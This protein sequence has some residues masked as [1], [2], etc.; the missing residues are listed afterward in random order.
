MNVC[1]LMS[2][3]L[4]AGAE[5]HLYNLVAY[6][7][8]DPVMRTS[9]VLL[10]RGKLYNRL[11]KLGIDVCLIDETR[12]S[13]LEIRRQLVSHLRKANPAI[14][15]SHRYKEN[16]L[17]AQV[18]DKCEVRH[19]V[20]TVHGMGERFAGWKHLRMKAYLALDRYVARKHFDRII[21]VSEDIQQQLRAIYPPDRIVTVH[22]AV[23]RNAL[24]SSRSGH[25]LRAELGFEPDQIL[26]GAAG[27]LVPV[28]G[29][30]ILI[31][32]SRRIIDKIPEVRLVLAG[33]GP[34]RA[35]LEEQ[36]HMSGLKGKVVLTGFREDIVDLL[37]D[38]DL[39]V[40]S[41]HHE[42]I[43]MVLLE[44]M[45]LKRP[46]VVTDVGGI[47]EVVRD[48]ESG[49]LV[50]PGEARGFADAC[51]RVLRNELLATDL[52]KAAQMRIDQEFSVEV[53]GEKTRALYTRLE[54]QS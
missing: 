4:W 22:N 51:L 35:E 33:D 11:T 48:C 24:E 18:K 17:A 3:D 36:V 15:H 44:A 53:M 8:N 46:V 26:V 47:R 42:G 37:A 30:D 31:K 52:G 10:N 2:G 5:T 21:T 28:K 6:L 20:Q 49:L 27:R 1:H 39:F 43:P 23:D 25:D 54:E 29:L 38:L 41:S 16:L 13:F 9:V 12:H 40:M 45:A 14:L 7:R 19:L 50:A 32:A 34:Q